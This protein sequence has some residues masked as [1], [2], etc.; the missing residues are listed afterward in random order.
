MAD[1]DGTATPTPGKDP[2]KL[3]GGSATLSE[4]VL[5]GM[6]DSQKARFSIG[7]DGVIPAM[8]LL[9]AEQATLGRNAQDLH[10]L[11][12]AGLC[13]GR[14]VRGRCRG[15]VRPVFQRYALC[16]TECAAIP[17]NA[18]CRAGRNGG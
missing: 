2:A 9:S 14:D 10:P 8:S 3:F 18:R 1:T 13:F 5:G 16:R 7:E 15:T 4:Q 11:P 12:P 6:P 17:F